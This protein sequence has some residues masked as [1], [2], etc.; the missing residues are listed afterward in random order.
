MTAQ[1]IEKQPRLAVTSGNLVVSVKNNT[2][3]VITGVTIA[4]QY[5][6][7][8]GNRRRLDRTIS[9]NIGP[10]KITRVNTGIGPYTA[11]SNCPVTVVTARVAE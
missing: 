4:V 3:L 1:P 6:D 9:G 10:G 7:N 11:G 2:S 5:T 8:A